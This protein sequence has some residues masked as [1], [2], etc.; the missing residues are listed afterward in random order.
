MAGWLAPVI[1]AIPPAGHP[2]HLE[3]H[4]DRAALGAMRSSARTASSWTVAS[5]RVAAGTALGQRLAPQQRRQRGRHPPPPPGAPRL[6]HAQPVEPGLQLRLPAKRRQVAEELQ[7]HLLAGVLELV[8]RVPSLRRN[9]E[10][11]R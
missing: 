9:E 6:G 2:F 10:A 8:G 7:E 3:Q 1:A 5:L 11:I 4:E